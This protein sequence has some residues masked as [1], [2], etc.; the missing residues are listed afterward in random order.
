MTMPKH[1]KGKGL[2]IALSC[3]DAPGNGLTIRSFVPVE[4]RLEFSS[5]VLEKTRLSDS[6]GLS[7]AVSFTDETRFY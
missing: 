3:E 6:L 1:G 4:C 2:G 7:M 5:E